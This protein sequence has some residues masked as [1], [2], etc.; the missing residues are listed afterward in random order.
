MRIALNIFK[1]EKQFEEQTVQKK[2][3]TIIGI[4]D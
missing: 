2:N 3:E 1:K 4:S